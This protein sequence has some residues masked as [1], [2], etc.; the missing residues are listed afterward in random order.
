MAR[1]IRF[2]PQN[3]VV[4][5]TLRT[6]HGR[7]LLRPTAETT[8]IVAGV[9]ARAQQLYCMEIHAVVVMSNHLHFLLSPRDAKQL[10]SFMCHV[11]GN[12]A[13]RV[14]SLVG[15]REKF[16]GR[17][18]RSIIVSNEEE[19]QVGRL[20]Y[21]L[22]HGAKEG[23][24][25]DPCDWP[26]IHCSRPLT[27]GTMTIAGVWH[28]GTAAYRGRMAGK[29]K[30]PNAYGKAVE[31]LLSPLPCWR[32]QSPKTQRQNVV[33]LLDEIRCETRKRHSR[34]G[35][36]PTGAHV[37]CSQH[38]HR[39]PRNAVRSPAPA[40]HT[41]TRHAWQVLRRAY[42]AFL[43]AYREAAIALRSGQWPV[44]FPKGCFPP[45]LPFVPG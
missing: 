43:L 11:A 7:L 30:A 38:P 16:W 10:S 21:F 39:R 32:D 31:I 33:A 29:K 22:A 44:A 15:W 35:T 13:R 28:D 25:L 42:A 5:T 2:V 3:H 8:R 45:S 9:I 18:Y 23:F 4:E 34:S 12:V 14:G 26:G 36:V 37:V 6:V 19:A 17:R 1:S 20:R 41:A 27:E 40:F 24:V